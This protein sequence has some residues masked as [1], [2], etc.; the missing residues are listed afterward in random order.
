MKSVGKFEVLCQTWLCII[1]RFAV[2]T[3][4]LF[5]FYLLVVIRRPCQKLFLTKYVVIN[6]VHGLF[7]L[8]KY[9]SCNLPFC[10]TIINFDLRLIYNTG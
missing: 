2:V 5:G 7:V 8:Y 10:G 1:N 6:E 9:L 4:L 3:N